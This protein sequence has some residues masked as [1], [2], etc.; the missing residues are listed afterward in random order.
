M[1]MVRKIFLSLRLSSVLMCIFTIYISLFHA[2]LLFLNFKEYDESLLTNLTMLEELEID[3]IKIR[4]ASLFMVHYPWSFLQVYLQFNTSELVIEHPLSKSS[5]EDFWGPFAVVSV[6]C[7]ILW[8]GNVKNIPW[9]IAIWASFAF[10]SHLVARVSHQSTY[11]LHATILGYSFA[12]LIPFCLLLMFF[13]RGEFYLLI[14]QVLVLSWSMLWVHVSFRELLFHK[15]SYF[16]RYFSPWV[17]F[18]LAD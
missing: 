10:L 2:S 1:W 4:K 15:V 8:V 3:L 13:H 6:Y 12:P 5:K 17:F 18:I 7:G 16:N 9:I 11:I 14:V